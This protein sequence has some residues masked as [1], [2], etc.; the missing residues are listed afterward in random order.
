MFI[1][2][3]H[4]IPV[5]GG[6]NYHFKRGMYRGDNKKKMQKGEGK[7]FGGEGRDTL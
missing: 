1:K 3:S 4:N 7:G 6:K 5:G 2:G